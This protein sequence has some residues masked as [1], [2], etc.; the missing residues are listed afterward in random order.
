MTCLSS[1]QLLLLK[2]PRRTL[3]H[4]LERLLKRTTCVFGITY[5]MQRPS[6]VY[7]KAAEAVCPPLLTYK[8]A[9]TESVQF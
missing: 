7:V 4:N 6:L 9:P 5:H 1:L 2:W 3:R 8:T